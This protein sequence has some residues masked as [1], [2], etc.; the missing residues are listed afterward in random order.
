[1]PELRQRRSL[2]PWIWISLHF[3]H[4]PQY[5]RDTD[6]TELSCRWQYRLDWIFSTTG[7]ALL[8]TLIYVL[9][10]RCW[11]QCVVT[12]DLQQLLQCQ[13]Q[14]GGTMETVVSIC[15]SKCSVRPTFMHHSHQPSHSWSECSTL[16]RV[17]ATA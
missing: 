17:P 2:S 5:R 4:R 9:G 10:I 3:N 14:G 13:S 12:S 15:N 7:S 6:D 16:G 11:S 1:L 8:N